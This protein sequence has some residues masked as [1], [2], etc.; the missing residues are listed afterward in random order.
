MKKSKPLLLTALILCLVVTGLW[1]Y[2]EWPMTM[3]TLIPAETWTRVEL[4]YGVANGAGHNMEFESPEMDRILPQMGAVRLTRAEK[5]T[6]LDDRYFQIILYNGETYPTMLYVGDTGRIQIA[7]HLDFDH[8]KDYEGGE[9]FFR[10]LEGYSQ[11]LP[12]VIEIP[13]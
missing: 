10:Y 12:A 6:Y 3:N 8:W 1:L 2:W 11:N 9:D 5:R 7:R 4:R 13:Q